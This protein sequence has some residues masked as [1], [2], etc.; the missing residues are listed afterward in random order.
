MSTVD[1]LLGLLHE[2]GCIFHI[3]DPRPGDDERRARKIRAL[4]A[5]YMGMADEKGR[6]YPHY[7]RH[8]E[9][10]RIHTH[11]PNIAAM[12][13]TFGSAPGLEYLM[14]TPRQQELAESVNMRG[15]H[16]L[17]AHI[18]L[19]GAYEAIG[20]EDNPRWIRG[21]MYMG[22]YR[23]G[24]HI[25]EYTESHLGIRGSTRW[26]DILRQYPGLG[27]HEGE[28]RDFTRDVQL[29]C[30]NQMVGIALAFEEEYPG[31]LVSLWHDTLVLEGRELGQYVP[32]FR[33][34]Y[35]RVTGLPYTILTE[36]DQT[37]PSKN[38]LDAR[39]KLLVD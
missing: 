9:V 2:R 25:E 3:A 7:K 18:A 19:D 36:G 1:E 34:A 5:K 29:R 27:S 31:L 35:R 14:V 20:I 33:N 4:Q 21:L 10:G 15:E 28:Q 24:S 11:D 39:L 8:K 12:R 17:A 22:I 32:W 38:P 30:A 23:R 6:I 37:T 13:G 26:A 16:A